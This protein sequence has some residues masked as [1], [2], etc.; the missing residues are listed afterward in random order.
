MTLCFPLLERFFRYPV[1]AWP[2][3][4]TEILSSG[5]TDWKIS[6][7]EETAEH[8]QRNKIK[9]GWEWEYSWVVTVGIRRWEQLIKPGNIV[10]LV[11]IENSQQRIQMVLTSRDIQFD[12]IDISIPGMQDMRSFMRE[13]GR[14]REGQRNVLPPQI[15][16]GEEYRG[17]RKFRWTQNDILTYSLRIMRG[18]ILLMKMMTLKNFLVS[19]GRIQRWTQK[20]S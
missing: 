6:V 11:Q 10:T 12:T 5:N 4:W 19:L 13:K 7:I 1:F 14:R 3:K 17:V 9:Q 15:F 8:T 16:N 18:L 20:W 2:V